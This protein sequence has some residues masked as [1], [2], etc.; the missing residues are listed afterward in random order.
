MPQSRSF[1]NALPI[2]RATWPILVL[3]VAAF[4]I[5]G[6]G[7]DDQG[8]AD[9]TE[10]T[11]S[12]EKAAVEQEAS[13]PDRSLVGDYSRALTRSDLK[14]AGISLAGPPEG[15]PTGD[16]GMTIEPD[17]LVFMLHPDGGDEQVTFEADAADRIIVSGGSYCSDPAATATYRWTEEG[18]NL[19]LDPIDF[20]CPHRSAVLAG[21]W[22]GE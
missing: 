13:P 10:N 15:L 5:A 3:A 14:R 17:G 20:D 2:H 22:R 6:C 19:V 9:E 4:A 7:D 18:N 11:T 16:L 21:S 1:A 8:S 12:D